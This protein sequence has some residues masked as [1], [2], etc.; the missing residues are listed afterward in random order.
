MKL[1]ATLSIALLV[2]SAS[3]SAGHHK[4]GED[5]A[6]VA[7]G[8]YITDTGQTNTL[9][10]GDTSR[11]QIWLDYIDAHNERDL[12]KVAAINAADWMGYGEQGEVIDGNDEHLAFLDD[13][14]KSEADPKWTVRWMIANKGANDDGSMEY[15]LTTGNDISFKDEDGNE[16][17][18]NHVH[19]VQFV[20][21]Q[22]KRINVY[23]RPATD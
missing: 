9:Y 3:A 4:E 1:Y 20:G 6:K 19:D 11:Q 22:I 16:V 14:F 2:I 13:W 23:S 7:I 21:D 8:S 12:E 5:K 10:A 18:Q 17:K 15:W